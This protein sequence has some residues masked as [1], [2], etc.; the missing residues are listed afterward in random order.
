MALQCGG[1]FDLEDGGM[2]ENVMDLLGNT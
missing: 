1:R 2:V